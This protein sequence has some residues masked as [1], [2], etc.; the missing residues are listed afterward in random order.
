M[1]E[2][3]DDPETAGKKLLNLATVACRVLDVGNLNTLS[4]HMEAYISAYDQTGEMAA[5][6]C[7]ENQMDYL[8]MDFQFR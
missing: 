7:N 3:D 8:Q 4:L 5:A 1:S 6:L 2:I